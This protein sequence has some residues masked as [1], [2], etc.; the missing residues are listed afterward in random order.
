MPDSIIALL[1]G[2]AQSQFGP[3]TNPFTENL[4]FGKVDVEPTQND[5]IEVTGNFRLEHNLTGGNG[6]MQHR[7]ACPIE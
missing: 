5:R 7:P 6:R 2:D 3:V 1:P 4:Y